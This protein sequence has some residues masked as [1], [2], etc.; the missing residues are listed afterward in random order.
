[1]ALRYGRGVYTSRTSSKANDYAIGSDRG[2]VRVMFLCK[3]LLGQPLKVK[4]DRL[5]E[6]YVDAHIAA[7][8]QGGQFDSVLGLK[9][10]A[11]GGSL[12]Y[13]EN[14]VY[15]VDQALPSYVIVYRL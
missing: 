2:G 12:N 5:N 4:E 3:V 8:G 6:A 13:E 15:A 9:L 14:V 10:G 7:R 1:M 11:D